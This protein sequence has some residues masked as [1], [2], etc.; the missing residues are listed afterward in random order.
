MTEAKK[1]QSVTAFL[2]WCKFSVNLIPQCLCFC[3]WGTT[4]SRKLPVSHL[5]THSLSSLHSLLPIPPERDGDSTGPLLTPRN[6]GSIAELHRFHPQ[7]QH[8]LR[9][10][11]L[12][13]DRL[14]LE[15][16]HLP[17]PPSPTFP[18]RLHRVARIPRQR[19]LSPLTSFTTES[20]SPPPFYAIESV[21]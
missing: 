20:P 19:H 14:L 15:T 8:T 21:T 13:C 12:I 18:R 9:C 1:S 7:P 10:H 6:L 5:R 11:S 2:L 3:A 17:P 4:Y 16:F